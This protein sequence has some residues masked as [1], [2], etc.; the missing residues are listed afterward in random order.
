MSAHECP[1]CG[2]Y[3]LRIYD[4]PDDLLCDPCVRSMRDS[5]EIAASEIGKATTASVD[6]CRRCVAAV[7]RMPDFAG[8]HEGR[9]HRGV[10]SGPRSH[11]RADRLGAVRCGPVHNLEPVEGVTRSA[12]I[13]VLESVFGETK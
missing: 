6:Q 2:G 3:V 7:E 11:D 4:A 13:A 1:K 10:L 8:R 12:V 9:T 5:M